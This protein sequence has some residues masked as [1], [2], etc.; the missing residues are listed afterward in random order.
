MFDPTADPTT[1]VSSGLILCFLKKSVY[2][3]KAKDILKV[4]FINV[5]KQKNL[6]CIFLEK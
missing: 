5:K 4:S 2:K 6:V 3:Y 1:E